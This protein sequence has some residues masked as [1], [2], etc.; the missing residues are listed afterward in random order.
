MEHIS[1]GVG[2]EGSRLSERSW[3]QA[4]VATYFHGHAQRLRVVA[5][6]SEAQLLFGSCSQKGHKLWD[7][8]RGA[9]AWLLHFRNCPRVCPMRKDKLC[10]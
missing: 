6:L 4:A 3:I 7:I 9:S 1:V 5:C 10:M 8:L 2:G